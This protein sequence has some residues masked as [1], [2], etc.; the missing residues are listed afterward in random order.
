MQNYLLNWVN[1]NKVNV[2]AALIYG[3]LSLEETSPSAQ[4]DAEVLLGCVLNTTRTY[5]Y[6][7][8]DEDV[9]E[10]KWHEYQL[11]IAQRAAG[12]PIA[13]LTGSK[14]FWSLSLSVTSDTLIPR[15]ETEL[16]VEQTLL[17]LSTL[18]KARILDLGTGSGAIALALA[19]ER[20]DWEIHAYDKSAQALEVAKQ[21]ALNLN[22]PQ[23]HF[24]QSDWFES[25]PQQAF[26]A[27]ISN[28]PYIAE[29]DPH[30][31]KGDVR[32]EPMTALVSGSK[33]LDD[34]EIIIAK[35]HHYLT[36]G[37]WLLIE[38]GFDQKN[39]VAELFARYRYTGIQSTKDGQ[40]HYRVTRGR[41]SALNND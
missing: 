24:G 25:V 33:G 41:F 27:I 30:L 5:L 14:E 21:N 11:I 6:T 34:I 31:L 4:L 35:A 2:K 26:D 22:L 20:P 15:P 18:K 38:H 37:G 9:T 32:F 40:G 23:I 17:R 39:A 13:Y 3:R 19:S 36:N 1:M 12:Q 8:S 16:L 28:P 7:H 10:A 29:H